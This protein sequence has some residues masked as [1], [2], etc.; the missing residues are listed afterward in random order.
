[1][2]SIMLR[3]A[4]DDLNDRIIDFNRYV[5]MG[6]LSVEYKDFGTDFESTTYTGGKINVRT[7]Q[8]YINDYIYDHKFKIA[9]RCKLKFFRKEAHELYY[10]CIDTIK[11]ELIHL[12]LYKKYEYLEDTEPY[13]IKIHSDLSPVFMIYCELCKAELSIESKNA[14]LYGFS[15]LFAQ[16]YKENYD[17][18]DGL[19]E[20]HSLIHIEFSDQAILKYF[21]AYAVFED[22]NV[23]YKKRGEVVFKSKQ[24]IDTFEKIKKVVRDRLCSWDIDI[25][26]QLKICS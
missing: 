22:L 19:Y 23:K 24:D 7:G 26:K 16:F 8:I 17:Y 9:N 20:L 12:Y 11:H 25:S 15:K 18:K 6:D 5:N 3:K 13:G 1:M 4:Y 21:N 10:E 14:D 2:L